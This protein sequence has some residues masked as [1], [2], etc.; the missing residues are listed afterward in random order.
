MP[1][2]DP[3]LSTDSKSNPTIE[4]YFNPKDGLARLCCGNCGSPR[5]RFLGK[6]MGS[7]CSN[8]G[9]PICDAERGW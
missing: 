1:S 4:F 7:V 5:F 9:S 3:K 6:G 8:C 2:D